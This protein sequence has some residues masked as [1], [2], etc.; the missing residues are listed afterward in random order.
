MPDRSSHDLP[1]DRQLGVN[2]EDIE[3]ERLHLQGFISSGGE[4]ASQQL[5]SQTT[6]H[7]YFRG[8]GGGASPASTPAR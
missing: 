7:E 3:A 5:R 8:M 1:A 2:L 4:P 6:L